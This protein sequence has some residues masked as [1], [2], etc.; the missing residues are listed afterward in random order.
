RYASFS[1]PVGY[2][3]I[4]LSPTPPAGNRRSPWSRG[5]L[6]CSADPRRHGGV[7][8][9]ERKLAD[10]EAAII[11]ILAGFL[12][13]PAPIGGGTDLIADLDL[14]SVQVMEFV[15]EVEDHYD[16]AIDL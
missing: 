3:I 7:E 5:R 4:P 6:L 15:M 13:N 16:I 9:L 10:I 1:S 12:K 14:E 11:Q 2:A 8:V